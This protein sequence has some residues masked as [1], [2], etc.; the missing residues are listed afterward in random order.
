MMRKEKFR[1]DTVLID[2]EHFDLKYILIDNKKI[3][4][5]YQSSDGFYTLDHHYYD[6]M[7]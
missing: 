3:K 7:R 6:D 1:F 5:N 4:K 2:D